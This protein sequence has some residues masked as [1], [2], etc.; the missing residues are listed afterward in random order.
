MILISYKQQYAVAAASNGT[1]LELSLQ[2]L[3]RLAVL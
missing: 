2:K 3:I 1:S